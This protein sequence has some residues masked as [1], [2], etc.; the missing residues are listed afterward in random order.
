MIDPEWDDYV[1]IF[2]PLVVIENA[3]GIE[4]ESEVDGPEFAYFNKFQNGDQPFKLDWV[5]MADGRN[6]LVSY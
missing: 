2:E 4:G 1:G 6:V 3:I 5:D